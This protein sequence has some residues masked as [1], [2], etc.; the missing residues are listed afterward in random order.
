M[1][2]LVVEDDSL[3]LWSLGQFLRKEGYDV[4]L[5]MK[6]ELA[7]EMAQEQSFD[8]IVTDFHLPDLNG[9]TL[10]RSLRSLNPTI[11][12]VVISAYQREETGGDSESLVDAYLNKPI[13]LKS[14]SCLLQ[15]LTAKTAL[16]AVQH[17]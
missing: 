3:F 2:A 16:G 14:L 15:G 4:F 12:S 5:A 17:S 8:V 9:R 10:I 1:K 11:K 7:F 13:E 6:A